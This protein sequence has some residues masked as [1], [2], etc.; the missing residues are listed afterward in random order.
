VGSTVSDGAVPV[1]GANIRASGEAKGGRASASEGGAVVAATTPWLPASL[2]RFSSLE[3][4]VVACPAVP[5]PWSAHF[6]FTVSKFHHAY[7]YI[8][9]N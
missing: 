1:T 2:A 3:V 8:H 4:Q 6:P 9:K 7:I 5:I